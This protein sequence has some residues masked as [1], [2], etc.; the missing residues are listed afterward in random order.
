M[1]RI[2]GKSALITG[3]G[4]G[5]GCA[6]AALLGSLGARVGIHDIHAASPEETAALLKAEGVV[7]EVFL[8]DIGDIAATKAMVASAE[9]AFG[10][11]DI[12]VNNAGIPGEFRPL[13]EVTE[14]H[15]LKAMRVHVGGTLFATQAIVAGM[16]ARGGGKIVNMSSISGTV[17]L[18]NVATYNAAKGA[19]LALTKGWAKE[20]APWKITVNAVAP[21]PTMTN[22]VSENLSNEFIEARSKALPLGR[23]GKPEEIAAAVAYLVSPGA[24]FVTGQ[25]ISPNGGFVIS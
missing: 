4:S 7:C 19:L 10:H 12:L 16:K 11:V 9:D 18:P 5:I 25:V 22:M 3:A 8:C 2:D 20:L 1:H 15:I 13:E 6:C 24:D 14:G 23:Y 17:G 21:G